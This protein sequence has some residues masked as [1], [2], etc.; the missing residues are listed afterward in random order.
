M[1]PSL[2]WEW[3]QVLE[4]V[5][6]TLNRP[7]TGIS[8]SAQSIIKLTRKHCIMSLKFHLAVRVWQK[9]TPVISQI[10]CKRNDH[11]GCIFL[12]FFVNELWC[13]VLRSLLHTSSETNLDLFTTSTPTSVPRRTHFQGP[14]SIYFTDVMLDDFFHKSALL[15]HSPLA[16]NMGTCDV[17]ISIR[18]SVTST[19]TQTACCIM[20][21]KCF[22]ASIYE[23]HV[24]QMLFYY[25]GRKPTGTQGIIKIVNTVFVKR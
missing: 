13:P 8:G 19:L 17:D 10:H 14:G 5:F 22:A 6:L 15:L 21:E 23:V 4:V 24:F 20:M 25:T 18:S 7:I 3:G 12:F 16:A 9:H 2:H 1:Y 11:G